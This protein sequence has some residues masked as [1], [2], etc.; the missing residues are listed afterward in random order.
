MFTFA[1]FSTVHASMPPLPR[2][3]LNCRDVNYQDEHF[4]HIDRCT[5]RDEVS[6][7]IS[8]ASC[9]RRTLATRRAGLAPLTQLASPQ[10]QPG[11]R[12]RAVHT[13]SPAYGDNGNTAQ[14][15]SVVPIVESLK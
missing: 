12:R 8:L 5:T 15:R 1:V 11:A 9:R 10:A 4:N 2:R 14:T 13:K 7:D 6:I 3:W